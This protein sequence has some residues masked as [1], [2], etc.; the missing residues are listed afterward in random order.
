M[1]SQELSS[2]DGIVARYT[3]WIERNR[4]RMLYFFSDEF[5]PKIQE[6]VNHLEQILECHPPARILDL[7]CGTG[8]ATIEMARRGYNMVG[9]DCTPA[10]L[11]IAKEMA[12]KKNVTAGW[13]LR[14]MRTIRYEQEFDYVLLRDVVFGVFGPK[15][16]HELV[17]GNIARALRPHGRL[18]LEVYNRQF[19][20]DHGVENRYLYDG[21]RDIFVDREISADGVCSEGDTIN[22]LPSADLDQMLETNGLVVIASSGTKWPKDPEPPPWRIDFLVAEKGHGRSAGSKKKG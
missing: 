5:W 7:A 18:L 15:C 19:A 14:D 2:L 3:N 4:D 12:A 8:T 20:I 13:V 17:L 22:M 1:A 11:E 10:T 21:V 16:E 9:L 6:Q